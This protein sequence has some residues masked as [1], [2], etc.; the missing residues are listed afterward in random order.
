MVS[1][2]ILNNQDDNQWYKDGVNLIQKN[3]KLKQNTNTAK[4][5]ILFLGD[6]MGITTTTAARILD[7]QMKGKSGEENVLSWEMFPWSGLAKTYSLDLQ[8]ADSA[9]SA[10]AFLNGV[11]TRDSKKINKEIIKQIKVKLKT[12]KTQKIG[13]ILR[14]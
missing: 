11:K 1:G 10:T 7:G 13:R 12:T 14:V 5:A 8:G 4:N 9:S 3:L 2:N 6:G